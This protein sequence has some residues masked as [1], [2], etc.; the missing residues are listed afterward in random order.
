MKSF[1][2]PGN[3]LGI[4]RSR[5]FGLIS[6]QEAKTY[7]CE[8]I[9]RD[10]YGNTTTFAFTITGEEGL[11]PEDKKE[12]ILFP[13]NRSNEYKEKGITLNIPEGNLYTNVYLN[14]DTNRTE[15][16]VFAPL[17]SFGKRIPLHG[18]CPLTL[19]I[20]NDSYSDK[21]KYGVVS[22]V[23]NRTVWL[24][25]EYES[26]KLKVRIRELGQFTVVVDT[27]PPVVVPQNPTKWTINKQISFKITD[28]LSGIDFYQGTFD[29]EFA[30]FEYDAKTH[31]LFCKYDTKRMKKGKQTLN[32]IVRDRAKNETRVSY[33]VEF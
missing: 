10:A 22:I 30:L 19:T 4:Y 23:D 33:A 14:P 1:I 17:Y 29:G 11:I 12:G 15:L 16:S 20:T 24:G 32:L 25:G 6:I 7:H 2:D 3:Q 9:L 8:Y 5:L 21:T 28:D 26:H 31:L 27:V 18:S 13:Y